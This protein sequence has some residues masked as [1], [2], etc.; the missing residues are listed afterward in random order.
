MARI[1]IVDDDLDILKMAD[2]ILSHSGHLVIT[3]DNALRALDLLEYTTI[4]LLISDANMPLYSGFELIKT[5]RSNPKYENLTVAMLT[6]LR[7]RK[8]VEKAVKLG[9]NDYIVKPI[10]PLLLIQK[11]NTILQKKQPE[12]KPEILFNTNEPESQA[13]LQ[14]HTQ[15][16]S[17]SELGIEI[18]STLP[19]KVGQS[20]NVT[21][22]FFQ[23]LGNQIP[24][25]KIISVEKSLV[26]EECWK[27]QLIFLGANESLLKNI[28]RWILTHGSSHKT[29]S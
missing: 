4:D 25:L 5:I 9:V 16:T 15:L 21:A 13:T 24:P 27:V 14:F 22:P 19:L 18:K 20:I 3:T 7:E 1:L 29:A 23:Y 8:D 12:Q 26:D 28:R 10:D 11:I 2:K 6:S 17:I